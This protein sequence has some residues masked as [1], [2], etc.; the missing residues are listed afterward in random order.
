VTRYVEAFSWTDSIGAFLNWHV[1]ERPLLHVCSGRSDWGDTTFDLYEPADVNGEWT[2]LPF[3]DDSYAAVFADPPWNSGYKSEVAAFVH[4]AMRVAPVAYL[5]AP[6]L[7][8]GAIAPLSK[9][10]V[11]QMP[12]VH[13]PVLLTRYER[14]GTQLSVLG[15]SE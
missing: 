1:T 6:W 8:G 5:M 2:A 10:W 13:A 9:V 11:R 15:G 7:Y 12:G 3:P 14:P 4:E